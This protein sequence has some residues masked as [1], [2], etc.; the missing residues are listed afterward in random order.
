MYAHVFL[1]FRL[2]RRGGNR[3]NT[4]N[5]GLGYANSN[6]DRSNANVNYGVRPGFPT[7]QTRRERPAGR[8]RDGRLRLPVERSRK[9]R[10]P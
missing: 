3:N 8:R 6:N 2:P 7:T 4:S 10:N 9:E 1:V 5:A